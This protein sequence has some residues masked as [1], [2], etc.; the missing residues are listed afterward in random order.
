MGY[1]REITDSEA[2][3]IKKMERKSPIDSEFRVY[4]NLNGDYILLYFRFEGANVL[5]AITMEFDEHVI[6]KFKT[7]KEVNRFYREERLGLM[8]DPLLD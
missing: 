8:F 1:L 6:A 5:D 2:K 4:K 3:F 7:R